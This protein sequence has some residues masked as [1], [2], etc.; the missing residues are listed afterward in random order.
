MGAGET[1]EVQVVYALPDR[2][3]VVTLRAAHGAT[4]GETILSSGLPA[5][6]PEI[7]LPEAKVGIFGRRVETSQLVRSGDRIEIYRPLV[8][9]PKVV[10]RERA[11]RRKKTAPR[12]SDGR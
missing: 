7:S 2:Q 11:A 6:F 12:L 10:R 4:V 8:A 1:F 3:R 5:E 9:D